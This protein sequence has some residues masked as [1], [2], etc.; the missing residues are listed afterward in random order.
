M[1]G[2]REL[3]KKK[4]KQRGGEEREMRKRGKRK[5]GEREKD[6]GRERCEERDGK[7]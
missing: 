6:V 1:R 7:G 3:W 2:E 5:C 4:D